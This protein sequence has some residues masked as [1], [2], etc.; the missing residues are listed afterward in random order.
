MK[1]LDNFKI[2]TKSGEEYDMSGYFG[3]LVRSLVISSPQPI[4]ETEKGEGSHGQIRLGKTWGPRLITAQCSWFAVDGQDVALLRNELFRKLMTLQEFYI[5]IDA[6]PGKRWKVEVAAEW[7]PEKLGTYGEFALEFVSHSP[8]SESIATSLTA[9][10]FDQLG[11]WQVGQG[12]IEANDMQYRHTTSSFRIYNP[13]DATVDPRNMP[14]AITYRG[15]S[16]NLEIRNVT[17]SD[18]WRY[19]GTTGSADRLA[20]AGTRSLKNDVVNVF[21]DT[22]RKLIRLAPGWNDIR[23]TGA[24]GSYSAEFDFR[25]YYL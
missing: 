1:G 16:T 25:F 6:E 14:L 2:V 9:K 4:I 10:D 17:T 19:T 5:V 8:F 7:S 24:S 22:N 18:V 3:V 23:L 11:V 15:A 20:I 13:G 12:L 21:R